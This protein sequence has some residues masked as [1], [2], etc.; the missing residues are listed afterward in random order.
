MIFIIASSGLSAQKLNIKINDQNNSGNQTYVRIG[1]LYDNGTI[2]EQE[3]D[4]IDYPASGSVVIMLFTS[5][6]APDHNRLQYYV[7]VKNTSNG[8][9]DDTWSSM[10][11][12]GQYYSTSGIDVTCDVP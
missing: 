4:T 12:S 5:N 7:W 11:D 6:I 2:I 1:Q 10:F 8:R 3:V 9:T